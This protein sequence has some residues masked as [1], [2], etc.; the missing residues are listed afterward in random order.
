MNKNLAE[1]FL[2]EQ[3]KTSR[4]LI[5]I[6]ILLIETENRHLL[7]TALELL[8]EQTQ[9]ITLENCVEEAP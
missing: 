4:N 3:L 6:S 7:A 5:D 8:Y 9:I 2:V 1:H